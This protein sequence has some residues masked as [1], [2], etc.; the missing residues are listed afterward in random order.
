MRAAYFVNQYPKV[1]HTFIR[2]EIVALEA[3]GVEVSRYSLRSNPDELLNPADSAEAKLTEYILDTPRPRIAAIFFG[4]LARNPG[5][6]WRVAVLAWRIGWGSE[7]G[8]LRHFIYVAEAAVLANWSARDGANHIH[9]HF[10]TNSATVAMFASGLS[11]L[12]F[13]FTAHG[14]D[15]VDGAAR[16]DMAEKIRR[17]SF[18]VGVSAYVRSQLLRRMPHALWAKLRIV[19]CGLDRE[20]LESPPVP[21]P[22]EPRLVCVGR[23]CEEKAQLLLVEAA[24]TLRARGVPLSLVL[25]GDGPLRAAIEDLIKAHGLEETVTITGWVTSQRVRDELTLARG[26]VLPSLMEGLPVAIM[27]AMALGRPVISTYISG[28]PEL[29]IPGETGWL[30]PAG[31]VVALADAMQRVLAAPGADLERMGAAARAR[32]AVRHDAGI[33]AL[34]LKALFESRAP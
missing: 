31:D 29:V 16:P 13:S 30:V 21:I 7:R 5:G 32:V 12:P 33:E 14:A 24:A 2:R 1:S 27:E 15:E 18:V 9:A 10:G 3:A 11:G 4:M 23:L 25:A 20:F 34:K 26:L 6:M 22:A 8:L 19:H 28:I 17:A